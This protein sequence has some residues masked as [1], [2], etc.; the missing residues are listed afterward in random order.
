[1]PGQLHK[2]IGKKATT[3]ATAIVTISGKLSANNGSALRS[4]TVA[5]S[6]FRT[7]TVPS[8]GWYVN[9]SSYARH[10]LITAVT[11]SGANYIITYTGGTAFTGGLNQAYSVTNH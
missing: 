6:D 2:S 8:P 5:K 1:M 3:G 9:Y 7:S 11:T 10:C 4:I